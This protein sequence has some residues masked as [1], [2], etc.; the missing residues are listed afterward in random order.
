MCPTCKNYIGRYD[1]NRGLIL[2]EVCNIQVN[3]K[4]PSYHDFF[5]TLDIEHELKN[6][7]E[8]NYTYYEEVISQR[9]A[10]NHDKFED[11]YDGKKYRQFVDSLA[12]NKKRAYATTILNSDGSPVFKSSKFAIWPIQIIVNEIPLQERIAKPIIYFLWFGHD[13]PNM[14]YF[15]RSFV[16][17]MNDFCTNGVPCKISNEIKLIYIYTICCC[18]DSIARA[19]MQGLIQFNGRWGCMKAKKFG[20]EEERLESI[21]RLMKCISGEHKNKHYITYNKHWRQDNPYLVLGRFLP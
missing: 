3:L 15:L 16:E 13:K 9:E 4:D 17:T 7:I 14:T 1:R 8:N 11:I 10:I 21:L 12:D 19:P 6:A 2:C 18:V 20:I 5:I